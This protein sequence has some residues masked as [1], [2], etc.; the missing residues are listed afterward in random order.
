MKEVGR[1]RALQKDS[2]SGGGLKVEGDVGAGFSSDGREVEGGRWAREG[3]A[4]PVFPFKRQQRQAM[5]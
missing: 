3:C 4:I 1:S 5:E 2:V